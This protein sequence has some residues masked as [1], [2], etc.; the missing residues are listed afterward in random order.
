VSQEEHSPVPNLPVPAIRNRW[1]VVIRNWDGIFAGVAA[2]FL[3]VI[4]ILATAAATGAMQLFNIFAWVIPSMSVVFTLVVVLVGSRVVSNVRERR[5]EAEAMHLGYERHRPAAEA[6]QQV[7]V[8][9][10]GERPLSCS[11]RPR[12]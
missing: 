9:A 5:Y 2:T 1:D 10:G 4:G 8:Q 3:I 12:A 11:K 6:P 7:N